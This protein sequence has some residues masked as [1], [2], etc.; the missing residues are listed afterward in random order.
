MKKILV[1]EDN[2]DIRANAAELLEL[3]N[4][5][6]IVAE[7]GKEGVQLALEH[8]PDLIIC[9]IMMPE[10]DGF[11]VLHAVKRNEITRNTPFI[12]LTARTERNE[13]RKGMD[14]GADDYI[15]KPFEGTELL[16]AVE[17]R[18]KKIESLKQDLGSDHH[19]TI[20]VLSAKQ[21]LEQLVE[22]RNTNKY[23]RKQIIY[24][25]GN[26]PN[27]LYY[28]IKGKVK[29]YRSND[30]GKELVTNLLR[31]GDFVGHIALLEKTN[32]KDGAEALE[33]CELAV[34]PKE[35]FDELIN[36]NPGVAKTFLQSMAGN[37]SEK[38]SRLMGIAYNSLRKKVAEALLAF[39]KKYGEGNG[40]ILPIDISRENLATIAGAATESVTRTLT[41]F[42]DEQLIDI[43]ERVITILD[44]KKLESL[45]N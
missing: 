21:A 36:A 9:D 42:K 35:D 27:R 24:T 15:T 40:A 39:Q 1:I 25:E 20:P 44:I 17:T 26:H 11:G 38:E 16:T 8:H 34:V 4:Y 43:K 28:I 37:I 10:L 18:L 14:S 3:S 13:V 23:K 12:F 19:E 2:S 5:D 22:N 41:D 32:Y 45:L 7:N 31:E 33:E 29:L 30:D 6:V